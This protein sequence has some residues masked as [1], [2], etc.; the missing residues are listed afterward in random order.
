MWS[1]VRHRATTAAAVVTVPVLV[2]VLAV[3]DQGFPLARL[4]LNDGGVWLTATSK[5]QLGR[6][7]AQVEELNGGLAASGSTFDVLQDEGDVLLVEPGSVAVVDPASVTLTTQVA[8]P[9][10]EVTMAAGV[11]AVVDPDGN[12]WV[13]PIAEL[14]SLRIATDA[15]DVE[16]GDGGAAVVARSG[17]VLAVAAQ[18]GAVTRIDVVDGVRQ[19]TPLGTLGAGEIDRLS[20]VGDEPVVLSGGTVRT[21]AGA[22]EVEG[23]ELALQQP[24]PESS[25]ALV[26]SRTAL[27]EVPLDG[28][29]VVSHPTEGSGVPA[30]PVRVDRCA[31]GAWASAIGSYLQLCDGGDAEVSNLEE[32]SSAD[33]LAF[34]VNRQVVVLNDT[35]RGR[36][37]MPLQDT[38]LRVPEWTQ[39][40]PE[41]E[42]DEA[43]EETE[44]SDTTQDLVTECSAEPAP[45]TAADDEFGVRPGRTTILPVIDN[46]S[47][48]DCG[49]LVVS[50]HDPL[51]AEFGRVEAIHGGRSLQVAVAADATGTAE[52]TY[53]IT[54]GQGTTAPSTARVRLTVRDG[55]LDSPPVQLRT[56]AVRVEQGGQTDHQALADFADP[57][58]DD[59][60]LVGATADPAAGSVRFRQDG[61]VTFR[62]DGGRLG[63]T[64]VTLLVSDGTSTTEGLLDVDVRPA[65]SLPPQIDPVHAVTYVDQPVTLRPLDAVRS[66][67]AEPARLAGVDEVVGAT[68]TTDL[69]GGTFT[70]SSARPGSHYVR[71]LVSAPPQQ[72]TGLARVDVRPW[73]ETPEPPVAVRD[74][75]FLPAGGEVTVDPLANDSDPAGK[76][77]VLQSVDVPPGSGLRVA[78]L[79][80]HLVQVTAER[81][82]EGPVALPYTVSNGQSS[83]VGEIVVHPVPPSS[84]SQPPV[85]KN[86]EVSVRTGGVVTIPVLE[87]AYDPDG[88]RLTLVPELAEPLGEG[89]GLLFVSGD[90]LRYQAPANALTAHATFAVRD[91]TGNETAA[92]LTV[93][94]H[95]SDPSAKPPPRPVDLVARVFEGDTVRIPVP[96]VGIDA[97]GDGVTLLGIATSPEMGRITAVGPDWLEYQALPGE[98]DTDEFTYAVEDWVGQRAV[99]TIRVGISPRPTGA[100]PVVARD[101][102]VTVRPGQRVEVRV[103]ANDVDSSGGDLTLDRV[104]EPSGAGAEVSGRRII[105]QAPEAPTVL[106]Y[107]Y[108]VSNSRGGRDTGVLTV[109]VVS[110]A[111]VLAP[112]ARDVVVSALDTLGRTEVSVNVLAVAQNPSGPLS[113]LEVSV[114]GSQSDVARVTPRG[115]VVVT[116]VDHAQ[117]VPYLL[118]NRTATSAS[119]YAFITVPALGFFPPTPRPKAPELRVASGEQLLIP[120]DEQVQ[121]APGRTASI[122]DPLA[123]SATK[124]DLSDPVRDATT[125]QFRSAPGYAGPASITV[126]V[127]DA[128]GPGDTSGRTAVITLQITVY[129]VDDHPPT[130]TPSVI[131]VAPGEAPLSVDLRAFTTGP[132]GASPTSGRY[133][134][135]LTAA[136]PAGFSGGISNGVLSIAAD[137]TTPKGRTDTL[138]VRIGYGRTG[139]IDT[140]IDLRVIASTRPTI[141]LV[142]RTITDGV[143]GR[144]STVAVLEGAFNPFPDSP[145]TVVG[146]TVETPGAGTAGASADTVSVRPAQGFIGQMVTRYRVR[147]V[148]GDPDREVEGRVVVVVR[149]KPAT[150]TAPRVG[151][152]RDRTVVLSWDAPDNRGAPITGYRVVASP[153]N[154]VRP[155]ASTTCTI[156]GLTNDVE[157][158][159]TVAAQNDVD[160]SEPS[161]PSAGARPDAM[162]D[163]PVAPTLDFGDGS[164]RA[165]W[166]APASAG[167]PISSYTVEISPAP[168]AGPASVTALTTSYTF[169]GLRNGTAYSVRV[170]A[171]NKAPEP[172][173]WSPSS[174]PMVPARAPEPPQ[175][176]ATPT[177][178]TVGRLI[179]IAWS[180]PGDNGDAVA[181]YEVVVDGPGGDTYPVPAGT[182]QMTFDRAQTKYPYR[183]SVRAR[184]KAGWG[185]AGSATASTFG[186]PTAPTTVSATAV[187][188]TGRID[189]RWSGAD[190]NGTPIQSYVVRLPDGGE[191]DVGG[192]TSYTFENLT[193]GASYAY[194]V[195]T[196]NGAGSSGW[197]AAASA[198]ATTA[199]GRPTV[200]VAVSGNATGGRPTQITIDR[201]SDVADGGGGTVTYTWV[202]SSDRGDSASGTFSGRSAQVDVSGWNLPFRGA[203]VTA[204]VTART[205]IGATE[206]TAAAE[207][208]WGQAPGAVQGLTITSDDPAS[209]ERVSVAWSVPASDGGI[210]VD[211][212]RVCWSVNGVEQ[213][214]DTVVGTTADKRLDRIGLPDPQPNDT[215]TVTVT[216]QNYRGAGQSTPATYTVVAP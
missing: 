211:S 199:P 135:T 109:H 167:S 148:T 146:A 126:P 30:A 78:I 128:S 163:A 210:G 70:F 71:F 97:D 35:L 61:S 102:E 125:L 74:R 91:A 79:E 92:T 20:A 216:A 103:L 21:L 214:C 132:E 160:W 17:A 2:L 10:A 22:V 156:D 165:T 173:G 143:E 113:D 1:S 66:S 147:D 105:V 28:G 203:R 208:S 122:A 162:P 8:V 57:D 104:L 44:T 50:E 43:E 64:T 42:P 15:P 107:A 93:R 60:V 75:A 32:M 100:A 166:A 47:S 108:T 188:G 45:P 54:D 52:L 7:N 154:I 209:P 171:H 95:Q 131:D 186:L 46:D 36:L 176:S 89:E 121:V 63:R 114:P 206:G 119:S 40:E 179:A 18:D 120:L 205:A 150:P 196:V 152:V 123:V 62:A 192:R 41:E 90:V 189:L 187:A 184:N 56:G 130:F 48:S 174:A 77:L 73:P 26:A 134:Y 76:V 12:A 112:I 164:V 24:G 149:G 72:A 136:V 82:L 27:L 129:A 13:R 23:D 170:R 118:T 153:G 195:R 151:E 11:V 34:R 87:D 157:Y 194:Q 37:W 65:G 58:G 181:Q 39:I 53:T 127:T 158:T 69:Q 106:Q 137:E 155:C 110:D 83:A 140:T 4:D 3:L 198:T 29:T 212:Y 85:V 86:V 51:P 115:D 175:V 141:R 116:L 138:S 180:V 67:S 5:L 16:L 38:D 207:V 144:Q 142:D 168:P 94:V 84:T 201:G 197:S 81:T 101:D 96:L 202:L 80:H 213:T 200:G 14:D 19:T 177:D 124:S 98:R 55:S 88:D 6:Y 68:I 111:P 99:A 117:T 185:A 133:A 204:T 215:V 59:L 33:V 183:V 49:I 145:M 25:R 9:G 191:L 172:S 31:H 169:S 182:Q 190:D 193:G 178:S 159:F 161:A 139:S